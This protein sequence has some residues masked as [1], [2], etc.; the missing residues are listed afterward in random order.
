[1]LHSANGKVECAILFVI[2]LKMS[3]TLPYLK[4]EI[5]SD[6]YKI[7]TIINKVRPIKVFEFDSLG[8]DVS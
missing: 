7:L 6:P 4:L 5:N 8:I 1:M 2:I 3:A